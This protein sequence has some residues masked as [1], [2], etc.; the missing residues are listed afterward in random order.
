M[1]KAYK[2][3]DAELFLA[4]STN[5]RNE[6]SL[7]VFTAGPRVNPCWHS[8]QCSTSFPFPRRKTTEVCQSPLDNSHK[9]ATSSPPCLLTR[10]LWLGGWQATQALIPFAPDFISHAQQQQQRQTGSVDGGKGN[11]SKSLLGYTSLVAYCVPRNVSFVA[12]FV[13]IYVQIIPPHLAESARRTRW[14]S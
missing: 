10:P 4:L 5:K 6:S 7:S 1:D 8:S 2:N 13:L 3:A 9:W 14:T 12:F 11:H